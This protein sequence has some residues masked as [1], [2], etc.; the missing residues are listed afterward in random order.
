MICFYGEELLATQGRGGPAPRRGNRHAERAPQGCYPCAGHDR[1]IAISVTSDDEWRVLCAE[2]GLGDDLPRLS[3]DERQR[4]HD[5]IDR[6]LSAFTKRHE[7]DELT[8]RLQERG[9]IAAPVADA[10]RVVDDRQLNYDRF[11]VELDHAEVGAIRQPGLAIELSETPATFRRAAPCLGQHN[12]EILG[13]ELGLSDEDLAALAADGLIADRPPPGA[14]F[15]KNAKKVAT[16]PASQAA[17]ARNE[18]R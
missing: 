2:A 10:E 14:S 18:S 11:W 16:P 1:W 8:L 4:R 9:V 6:A 12:A 17:A 3:F 13:G 5:E 15:R 7:A